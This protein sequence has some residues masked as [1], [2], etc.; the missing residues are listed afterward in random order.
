MRIALGLEYDGGRF[1][2]WQSQPSGCGVQD[3]L[4]RAVSQ[5]AGGLVAITGAGRTDS[6]VHAL[7]QV[8]HFEAPAS[9]PETAWVRGVSAH[10]PQGVVVLWARQVASDFHARYCARERC[11]HYVLLN[12]AVRP[13][14]WAG[15]V[16]WHHAPL[17]IERMLAGVPYLL[18]R[19][20]F[21]A[22]RSA[23][24]QARSPVRDMRALSIIR[25]G[26]FVV[27]ELRADAFLQRMVRNIV[28]SLLYVGNNRRPP[29][30]IYEVLDARQRSRAAPTI[31]PEGLYLSGVRYDEIWQLP[32]PDRITPSFF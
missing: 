26:D 1:C 4:Q 18:G 21:S 9:R 2:G 19:H 20:D 10:L 3:A 17:D 30:W 28:G 5:I 8:A 7:L 29:E 6:G 23:E 16:G 31:G 25:Q 11:Y 24:C 12:R 32:Q 22:F 14:T 15:K 27:F 13:A